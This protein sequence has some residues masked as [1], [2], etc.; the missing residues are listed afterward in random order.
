MSVRSA[1]GP[2]SVTEIAFPSEPRLN[3]NVR[4][5]PPPMLALDQPLEADAGALVAAY[6]IPAWLDRIRD[7]YARLVSVMLP[8]RPGG[9]ARRSV[10]G[11]IVA[12][13]A[14]TRPILQIS[15]PSPGVKWARPD[16]KSRPAE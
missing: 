5:A 7:D 3:V 16:D 14:G 10:G 12:G 13:V 8:T 11:A 15:D 1:P 6:R 9:A 2:F 4:G